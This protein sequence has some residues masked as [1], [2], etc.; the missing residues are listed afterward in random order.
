MTDLGIDAEMGSPIA[1]DYSR[2]GRRT[3]YILAFVVDE[4]SIDGEL[5]HSAHELWGK[6][7][8][9]P[10]IDTPHSLPPLRSRVTSQCDENQSCR[11]ASQAS[12]TDMPGR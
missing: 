3:Y 2:D 1:T 9:K 10:I 11:R 6:K 4:T 7:L 12:S 8:F 5:T